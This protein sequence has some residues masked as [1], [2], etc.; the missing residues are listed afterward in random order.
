MPTAFNG[1]EVMV[2]YAVGPG[3]GGGIGRR[4]GLKIRFW[5]QS[6]SSSL[7]PG[8]PGSTH[9]P[10]R[11]AIGR[12]FLNNQSLEAFQ[13]LVTPTPIRYTS[14]PPVLQKGLQ[15]ARAS[16]RN[17]VVQNV[18]QGKLTVK[19]VRAIS[20]PGLYGDGNTLF[21]RVAPGGSKQWVQRLTVNGKRRN[22]GLGGCGWVTLAEAREAAL[23]NP[24]LARRGGDPLAEKHREK[25]P[26]FR[27]AAQRTY[28]SLRPR[29]RSK[30]VAVNWMQ[31]LERHAFKS[32][33][34]RC[35]WTASGARTCWRC[36]RLSGPRSPKP[37]GAYAAISGPHSS[38]ARRT[39]GCSSTPRARRSTGRC[40]GCRPSARTCG[41]CPGGNCRH[42]LDT[43]DASSAT[44]TAKLA[45]RFLILTASRPGEV[46]GATWEEIDIGERIWR[47]PGERM[48]AGAEHRVPLSRAALE[49]LERARVLDDGSGL[50][51]PSPVRRGRPFSDAT[52]TR[53]LHKTGLAKRATV[54]G[55]RSTFRDWCADTGKAREVAEAALAHSVGGV[56]GAYFRSDLFE[57][58]RRLMDAWAAYVA[59]ADNKVVALHG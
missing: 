42:A 7:S 30:T 59:G 18:I 4:A 46:R 32:A 27:E 41:R 49:V 9:A 28:E 26:T 57:R 8:I 58:R 55:F 16:S 23:Q 12:Q 48:K 45:L 44:L 36:S 56:E 43:V 17:R 39:D 21:L 37:P 15:A 29:W 14:R 10:P 22:I 19:L 5:Q 20:E 47:I 51:F 50:V 3:R 52:L 33:S 38:G 35:R 11:A 54:H 6:E 13:V 53:V 31:Q 2:S 25:A 24:R 1:R 34:G 40:R